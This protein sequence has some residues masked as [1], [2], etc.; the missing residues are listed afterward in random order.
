MQTQKQRIGA[1]GE[2]IATRFL[3]RKGYQ[4]VY[5]N[6][7]TPM[8]ELDLVGWHEK[9]L[10]GRTLCF[11]EVKT[12][13]SYKESGAR[14]TNRYEKMRAFERAAK[15]FCLAYQIDMDKTPIQFEHMTV[16]GSPGRATARVQHLIIPMQ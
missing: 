3:I 7:R 4:V 1:W 11:V 6:F 12:R 16:M 15:A 10:F 14:A 8:G 2:E 5:R 13:G 9:K